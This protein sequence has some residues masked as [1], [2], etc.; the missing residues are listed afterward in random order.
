MD[1]DS[2]C[3]ISIVESARGN[4]SESINAIENVFKVDPLS[5]IP[6]YLKSLNLMR[7]RKYDMAL[8]YVNGFLDNYPDHINSLNARGL[9]YLRS[10]RAEDALE[11]FKSMPITEPGIPYYGGMGMAY[12]LLGNVVEAEKCLELANENDSR[13]HLSYKENPNVIINF[14]LG[15]Y[16][17]GFKHLQKDIKE[18]RWYLRF[19]KTNPFFDFISEDER[20]QGLSNMLIESVDINNIKT[21]Y[22][23]SGLDDSEIAIID[24]QLNAYFFEEKPYL[25]ANLSLT[26]LA[27]SLNI[28]A[29]NLS[30][31]IN[32]QKKKNFFDFVNTYRIEA[33][34][35]K[36]KNS[37]N[38]KYT[39]LSLA[40]EVGFNSKSTFN[41]SF[42]KLMGKTP[43]DYLKTL[44]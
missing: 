34:I 30:Q 38:K 37:E 3:F 24:S 27:K 33:I 20:A 17:I 29:N 14:L 32:S 7:L 8:E 13:I 44:D 9:I 16:D 25:D 1:V 40:Y 39:L 22:S 42:K 5:I 21:K 2:Y 28:S 41:A 15:R 23:K 36:L 4:Y 12:A 35:E 43:S 11:V 6:H 19:Y 31:V 18:K 26:G 10:N